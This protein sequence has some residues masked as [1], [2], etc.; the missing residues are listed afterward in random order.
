MSMTDMTKSMPTSTTITM[1]SMAASATPG[2]SMSNTDGGVM[3]ASEMM[4]VFFT[5]TNTPLYSTAWMPHNAGQ[6]TG[7]CIFLIALAVIFRGLVALRCNFVALYDRRQQQ[8]RVDLRYA[9]DD[10]YLKQAQR[11]WTVNE[12]ATRAVLD[13]VLVGVSYLLMLAV[14]AMNVGYFLSVLGGTFLGSFVV[15]GW[16]GTAAH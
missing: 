2:S 15:G 8:R 11:P 14:M 9:A 3:G 4:M 12:A 1:S 13:T 5:A 10:Q 16:T 7:T 6:Y